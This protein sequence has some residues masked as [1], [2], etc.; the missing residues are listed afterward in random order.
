MSKD[1]SFSR[2]NI[3]GNL[4]GIIKNG[5]GKLICCGQPM[6]KLVANTAEASTEKHLPVV[7][8]VGE[9][10]IVKVGAVP[11]PMVPEHFIEWIALTDGL[12]TERIALTPDA[13]PEV[14]FN[15]TGAV[16]VYA[17]C[18]LHGLWKVHAEA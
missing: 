13:K 7:E 4:V 3:C 10:L 5:G 2:C 8:K 6:E 9:Q 17:Y 16:D 14:V 18:N 1:L 11:H 15:T 12:H